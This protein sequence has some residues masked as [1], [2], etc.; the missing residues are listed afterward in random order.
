MSEQSA[1]DDYYVN[2]VIMQS[3]VVNGGPLGQSP[4]SVLY[5]DVIADDSLGSYERSAA[6]TVCEP[7]QELLNDEFQVRCFGNPTRLWIANGLC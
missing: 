1:A 3:E 6:V 2:A 4:V 7:Q 5:V